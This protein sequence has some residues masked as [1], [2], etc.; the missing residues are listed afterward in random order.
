[1][2]RPQSRL[3]SRPTIMAQLDRGDDREE[4]AADGSEDR[5]VEV[6]GEGEGPGGLLL[7]PRLR[8][9]SRDR[10]GPDLPGQIQREYEVCVYIKPEGSGGPGAPARD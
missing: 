10:Y 6:A 7:D 2:P 4:G 5:V 8:N 1:M 9:P 3:E